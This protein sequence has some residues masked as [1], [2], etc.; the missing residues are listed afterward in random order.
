[1]QTEK[2]A[3][4]ESVDREEQRAQWYLPSIARNDPEDPMGVDGSHALFGK[5]EYRCGQSADCV[6]DR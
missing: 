3:S 2:G 1:M 4:I 5:A 6:T